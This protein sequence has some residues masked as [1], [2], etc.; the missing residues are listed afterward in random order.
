MKWCMGVQCSDCREFLRMH[1]FLTADPHITYAGLCSHSTDGSDV[2]NEE[3]S[4]A[5]NEERVKGT[6][7]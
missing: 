3:D 2:D 4:A 7:Q 6:G 5:E 1:A